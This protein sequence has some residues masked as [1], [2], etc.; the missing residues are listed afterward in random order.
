MNN[1]QSQRD[2]AFS[3]A[4][5]VIAVHDL[6]C[7]GRCALTLVI[8]TLAAMGVQPV[9]LEQAAGKWR[10]LSDELHAR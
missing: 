4:K 2:A 5:S 10:A 6:S 1:N 3:P 7:F 8:P 9:P